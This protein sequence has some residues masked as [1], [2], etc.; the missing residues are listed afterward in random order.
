MKIVMVVD[1][2]PLSPRVKKIRNSLLKIDKITEIKVIAWN[3]TSAPVKEEYVLGFN[4]KIGYGNFVQSTKNLNKFLDFA[5][6]K[7][8]QEKPEYV[9]L[10]DYSM[11]KLSSKLKKDSKIIY[12]VYDIKFFKNKLVN[13]FR[14]VSEKRLI[15][16]YVN[17]IILASPF[18]EI[19]YNNQ[20]NI[21]KKMIVIN[22]RPSSDTIQ[23]SEGKVIKEKIKKFKDERI[24]IA[25]IGTVRY[26]EIIKNLINSISKLDIY[27]VLIAGDGPEYI[28][29]KE[30]SKNNKQV[31]FLGRFDTEDLTT[32]Y[33]ESDIIWGVYPNKDENVK[34][35]V[36]NKF[37][38]SQIF[39]KPVL[40]SENTNLAKLVNDIKVGTSVNPYSLDSIRN[41]I[42]KISTIDYE[43]KEEI[44]WEDEEYLLNELF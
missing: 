20:L 21:Q 3:R 8:S 7:I 37:F 35:A 26:K 23:Y 1:H 18:F 22:N 40:V 19:Y 13:S 29:L 12:E 25:F 6:K 2:Y 44:F 34:Y 28:E 11:L 43:W 27:C 33:S 38:E 42:K 16:K 39:Q 30:Y 4:Q 14:E 24:C 9:H 41:G 31:L 36:S 17:N 32:I 15:N 5:Q 10:I